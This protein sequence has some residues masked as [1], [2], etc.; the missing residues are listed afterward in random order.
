V[1]GKRRIFNRQVEKVEKVLLLLLLLLVRLCGEF[2]FRIA[3]DRV[4]KYRQRLYHEKGA[5][6]MIGKRRI[7]NRQV[8]KVEKVLGRG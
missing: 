5:L 3:G 6:S 8:E 4:W 1:I 2:L 7:F